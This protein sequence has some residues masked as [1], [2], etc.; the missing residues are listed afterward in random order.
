[1]NHPE[2]PAGASQPALGI[3]VGV[4][5]SKRRLDACSDPSGER[6]AFANGRPG[7]RALRDWARSAW[8]WSRPGATTMAF[9]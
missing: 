6:R 3:T 2:T 8:R 4:D 1:M 5:V 7:R 9:V